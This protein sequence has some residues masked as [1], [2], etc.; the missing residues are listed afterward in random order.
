MSTITDLG[1]PLVFNSRAE[2][3]W[4]RDGVILIENA[5]RI[6]RVPAA[7]GVPSTVTQLKPGEQAHVDPKFLPDGRHFL[8]V[9]LGQ[10]DVAGI[11]L[12]ALDDP[13]PARLVAGASRAVYANGRLLFIRDEQLISQSFDASENRLLGA[14]QS[15]GEP[16]VFSQRS[17]VSVSQ[18]GSLVYTTGVIPDRQLLWVDKGGREISKVGVPALWANFDLSPEGDRI[19][20]AQAQSTGGGSRRRHL[21]P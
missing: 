2:G 10:P 14:P 8:F 5:G 13:G 3:S 15:A 4:N 1:E 20:A 6:V 9:V 12:D 18:T 7:G 16:G 21:A 19:I 17:T 11:W